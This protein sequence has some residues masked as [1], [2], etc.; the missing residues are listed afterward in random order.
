[1]RCLDIVGARHKSTSCRFGSG[2]GGGISQ[3]VS[4]VA[5]FVGAALFLLPRT[6]VLGAIIQKTGDEKAAGVGVRG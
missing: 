6:P 4:D 1:M 3:A 5:I 2:L